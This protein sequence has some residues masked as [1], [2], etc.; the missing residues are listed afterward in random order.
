M[1]LWHKWLHRCS[2]PNKWQSPFSRENGWSLEENNLV[3]KPKKMTM[4][5]GLANFWRCSKYSEV[6]LF[7][8][9]W[10]CFNWCLQSY[11]P[12][13]YPNAHE[14]LYFLL[15]EYECR[16]C[17]GVIYW[18]MYIEFAVW[19][20]LFWVV[21]FFANVNTWNFPPPLLF[22]V[23]IPFCYMGWDSQKGMLFANMN[24]FS[25]WS[26]EEI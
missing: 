10:F 3:L 6:L 15:L 25:F 20:Y 1:L 11:C 26:G 14:V 17:R 22:E 2:Y 8:L 13:L 16:I 21:H 5:Q 23:G 18:Q 12:I 19:V 7:L 9:D 4:A 24:L